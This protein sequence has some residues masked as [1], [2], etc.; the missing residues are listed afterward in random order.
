MAMTLDSGALIAVDRGNRAV[1]VMIKE[2]IFR[3]QVI[4]VPAPVVGQVWRDGSRQSRLAKLLKGCRV[5]W[6]ARYSNHNPAGERLERL[7]NAVSVLRNTPLRAAAAGRHPVDR[8]WWCHP[9]DGR[10]EQRR[11]GTARAQ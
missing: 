6:T 1:H 10:C 3:R 9:A 2:A 5:D 7:H 8:S 11:R 4:T